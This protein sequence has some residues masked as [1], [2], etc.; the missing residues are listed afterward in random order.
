M[1]GLLK[2]VLGFAAGIGAGA[3]VKNAIVH[4]TP[5]TMTKF[6]KIATTVGTYVLIGIA[7]DAATTHV[8]KQLDDMRDAVVGLDTAVKELKTE[9]A[10]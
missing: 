4:I 5:E 9:G 6:G 3:V 8:E 7:A 1:F 2:G 10:E